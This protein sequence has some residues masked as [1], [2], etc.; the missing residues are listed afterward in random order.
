M[1]PSI[2][3]RAETLQVLRLIASEPILMLAGD[4]DGC[5]S[6][7]TISGQQV[8]PAIARYLMESGFVVEIGKTELGARKL[9]LTESGLQFRETGLHWW[10]ELNLVQKIRITL[11]G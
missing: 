10:S 2:P 3:H 5:G 11:L 9:V 6:R 8:Q 4:D 1:L 7:W